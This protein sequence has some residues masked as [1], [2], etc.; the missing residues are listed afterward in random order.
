LPKRRG[1]LIPS[2]Q[3]AKNGGKPAHEI[4]KLF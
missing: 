1:V 3:Y 4:G 2:S